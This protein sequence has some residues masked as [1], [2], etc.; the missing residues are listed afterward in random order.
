MLEVCLAGTGGM[1]P[2]PQRYLTTCCIEHDGHALLVDCGE[3]TQ[4]ALRASR[5]HQS[6]IDMMLI[7]HLHG[8][9]IAGLPGLLLSMGN[10]GKTEPLE[11]VGVKGTAHAVKS[12]CC[13]C[14]ALPF[15]VRVT[16]LECEHSTFY[17][18]DV[19]IATLPLRHTMPCLG[20]S[21]T[22]YRKPIFNAQKAQLLGVPV[23]LW[24]Q[25]HEGRSV[26]IDGRE[27]TTDMVTD[28]IRLPVKLTY[29]TDSEYFE[30]MVGFAKDSDLLICEGMY[31]G[32]EFRE[33]VSEKKHMLADDAAALAKG[34]CSEE[35]W[36]T[37]YSP[38][39]ANPCEFAEYITAQ[40]AHC[41]VSHDGQRTTLRGR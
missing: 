19:E 3:G 31:F 6:H 7:T 22:L 27:I 30:E 25:L 28:G 2:L 9:H 18:H 14:P 12:L 11:I 35:L 15:E 26:L 10:S 38:A 24:K 21:L 40:F 13:I 41:T 23:T 8:D 32:E 4:I 20:Y 39:V 34:S 37:H 29:I 1:M 17:W 36:L 16:E 5:C 33:R